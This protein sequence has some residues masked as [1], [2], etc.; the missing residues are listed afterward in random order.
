MLLDCDR[1]CKNADHS[2]GSLSAGNQR[3]YFIDVVA[4]KSKNKVH[5]MTN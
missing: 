3:R 2:Q 5:H 4:K 1:D